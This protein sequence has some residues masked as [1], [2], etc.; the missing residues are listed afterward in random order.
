VQR[1]LLIAAMLL[2]LVFLAVGGYNFML[3]AA[4]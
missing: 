4:K 3:G 2:A 1:P